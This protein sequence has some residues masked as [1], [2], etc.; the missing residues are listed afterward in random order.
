MCVYCS[1]L[2]ARFL[3]K[4]HYHSRES[5]DGNIPFRILHKP[6]SLRRDP[7]RHCLD[8][9]LYIC[10]LFM[11]ESAL[12]SSHWG[13]Q[14]TEGHHMVEE[15]SVCGALQSHYARRHW[16]H[17]SVYVTAS[18]WKIPGGK[19]IYSSTALKAKIKVLDY[20]IILIVCNFS[21]TPLHIRGKWCTF[22]LI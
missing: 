15:S 21:S 5:R 7:L 14:C 20:L 4:A 22:T 2:N 3:L 17:H 6:L 13:P 9:H 1:A 16:P 19:L 12:L 10:P 18:V 11:Y 8:C